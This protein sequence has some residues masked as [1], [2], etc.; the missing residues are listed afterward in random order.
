MSFDRKVADVLRRHLKGE[1]LTDEV[2]LRAYSTDASPYQ[3]MPQAVARPRDRNDAIAV[4]QIAAE[5]GV[6]LIPRAAGT[7]LAGQCVGDGVVV[8]MGRYQNAILDFDP[9]IRRVTVQPGIVRDV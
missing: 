9:G 3:V 7:S 5:H 4:M 2:T 1:V 6:P 8:D